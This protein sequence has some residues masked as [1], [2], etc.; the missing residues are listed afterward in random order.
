MTD[1][2]HLRDLE[3]ELAVAKA[4][5][6]QAN[7]KLAQSQLAEQRRDLILDCIR[8]IRGDVNDATLVERLCEIQG[9]LR[10]GVLKGERQPSRE[11]VIKTKGSA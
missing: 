11:K 1:L 9:F 8:D 2:I 3:I 7:A 4:A 5:L 10:H 6:A